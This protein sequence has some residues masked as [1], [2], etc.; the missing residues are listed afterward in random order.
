MPSGFKEYL[1]IQPKPPVNNTVVFLKKE[2]K[3]LRIRK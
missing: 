1:R 2:I 3:T